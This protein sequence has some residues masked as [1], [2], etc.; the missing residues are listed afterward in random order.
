MSR[1]VFCFTPMRGGAVVIANFNA[2]D[3]EAWQQRAPIGA[4]ILDA[5]ERLVATRLESGWLFEVRT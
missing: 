5:L 4:R 3:L 2:S 1:V